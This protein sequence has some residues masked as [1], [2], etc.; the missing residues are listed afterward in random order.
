MC[1]RIHVRPNRV[2]PYNYHRL[3]W[4]YFRPF[5]SRTKVR[6]KTRNTERENKFSLDVGVVS[7]FVAC[8]T[9]SELQTRA[10]IPE[11]CI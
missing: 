1:S 5:Q 4:R 11:I 6:F 10:R 2:R 9:K 3:V 8:I 7:P